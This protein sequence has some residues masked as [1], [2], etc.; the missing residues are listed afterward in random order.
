MGSAPPDSGTPARYTAICV[1]LEP[2]I[3]SVAKE[4]SAPSL[5]TCTPG[6]GST[7]LAASVIS[8]GESS[9]RARD[10]KPPA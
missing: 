4:S 1:E 5:L 3:E 2:R 8:R 6:S 10:T 7:R 9:I